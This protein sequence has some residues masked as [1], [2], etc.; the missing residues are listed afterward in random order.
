MNLRKL[1]SRFRRDERGNVLIM[2]G[3]S[4][5]ALVGGAGLATDG[6]QWFLWK[7][8]IQL[9][10]DA[11]A[12]GAAYTIGQG[13]TAVTDPA[14]REIQRNSNG[15]Y[16]IEY[17]GTPPRSGAFAGDSNAAE[18]VLTTQRRLPF[19]GLFLTTR[20]SSAHERWLQRSSRRTIALSRWRTPA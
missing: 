14:T 15:V 8:Q 4:A 13:S 7:R 11:G 12:L 10:A 9:A 19:S 16:T 5:F 17:I 1:I 3:I 6:T 20:R 2:A 18:V